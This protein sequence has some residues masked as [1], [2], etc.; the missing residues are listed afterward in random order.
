MNLSTHNWIQWLGAVHV[1]LKGSSIAR[2]KAKQMSK[3]NILAA[4]VGSMASKASRF[5]GKMQ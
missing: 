2:K 3:I 5:G 1:K 4:R